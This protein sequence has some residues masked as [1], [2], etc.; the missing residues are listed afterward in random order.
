MDALGIHLL[1][2]S[3]GGERIDANDVRDVIYYIIRNAGRA[4]VREKTGYLP[5]S[6]PW[7]RGVRVDIVISEPARGHTLPDVVI[8]DLTRVDLVA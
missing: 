8:A 3:H 5:S 2:C 6:I 7:D 1:R 4:V